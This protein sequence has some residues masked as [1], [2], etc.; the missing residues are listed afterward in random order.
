MPQKVKP[1]HTTNITELVRVVRKEKMG[2]PIDH[3]CNNRVGSP[4]LSRT[5]TNE[6]LAKSYIKV[7]RLCTF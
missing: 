6:T 2:T 3:A 7:V 1:I 5:E 4:K